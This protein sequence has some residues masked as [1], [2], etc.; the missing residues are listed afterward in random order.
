M[1]GYYE[2]LMVDT[3]INIF[4]SYKNNQT[5]STDA[6]DRICAWLR[7]NQI[8]PI[9]DCYKLENGDS[10]LSYMNSMR[11]CNGVILILCKDYF[12]SINCMYEGISAM[13]N[14]RKTCKI[15]MVEDGIF[16]SR[17][18]TLIDDYWRNYNELDIIGL[19]REKIHLIKEHYVEFV[20]WVSDVFISKL[21]NLECE[22]KRHA[23]E[24]FIKSYDYLS[25]VTD[26]ENSSM[27]IISKVNDSTFEEKYEYIDMSYTVD[28]SPVKKLRGL[29]RFTL[30]LKNISSGE[31]TTLS[32]NDVVGI[33]EYR[34][35]GVDKY[36]TYYFCI[37]KRDSIENATW[38]ENICEKTPDIDIDKRRILVYYK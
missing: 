13:I 30:K 4:I 36:S 22:L 11:N 5:E 1:N 6:A 12:T 25:L 34:R 31:L 15:F 32:I 8:N 7:I 20:S 29:Y 27:V 9:R 17:F 14:H 10:I 35:P 37:A 3:D 28:E 24:I 38:K 16:D 2:Q 19:D 33:E 26:L 23:A 18:K 21:N